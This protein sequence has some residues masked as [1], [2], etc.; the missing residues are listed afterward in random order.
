MS[1]SSSSSTTA[2][3]TGTAR[4]RGRRTGTVLDG[5]LSGVLTDLRERQ[6]MV[7]ET[8][9]RGAIDLLATP[10]DPLPALRRP[11]LSVIS[12]VK[13]S[14]PSKGALAEIP[15]PAG[16]ARRYQNG[17]AAAISVLTEQRR[18]SGSLA[19]LDAVRAAV[20]IPV[21][22]KDFVVTEYQVLEARA[23][24]ADIVLLI[25][26]ALDDRE[27]AGLHRLVVS[28][29]MTPLVEVHTP[30]EARRAADLGAVLIGVNARNLKTLAVD[31]SNFGR[32]LDLLPDQAV[33]VAE[34]GI[35]S[36]EDA[37][38]AHRAGAD[39]ILV[40]E[41]LVRAED[42]GALIS[43]ISSSTAAVPGPGTVDPPL[44]GGS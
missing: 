2:S 39:A 34:S 32:L 5:I 8:S 36:L 16:L 24:G 29:G 17:G 37:V 38:D 19:D 7:S 43:A 20:S 42:P 44:S 22:R 25:V 31:T 10:L 1:A 15:D 18:F 26:A 4:V 12:E 28:L 21:L 9:L 35:L 23:H 11:G 33:K 14:S 3:S 41:A 27:L 40:G 6:L 13:R 30:D